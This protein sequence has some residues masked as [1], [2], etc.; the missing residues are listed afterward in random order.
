LIITKITNATRASPR[1]PNT[2]CTDPFLSFMIVTVVN[3]LVVSLFCHRNT[4]F[5]H[6]EGYKYFCF[7]VVQS[8]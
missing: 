7:S 6:A 5:E 4:S 2:K 3:P 8:T 1:N